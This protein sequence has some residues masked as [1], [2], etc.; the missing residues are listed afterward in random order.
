MGGKA[1][2]RGWASYPHV[3]R[4]PLPCLG[5]NSIAQ[6]KESG[7]AAVDIVGNQ[8]GKSGGAWVM[9]A[10]AARAACIRI[11]TN[12]HQGWWRC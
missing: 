10:R 7:K 5:C 2:A 11:L 4:P 8:I 9:Q 12:N 6:E 3:P 1:A